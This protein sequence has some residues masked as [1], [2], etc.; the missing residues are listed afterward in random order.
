MNR[1]Q[2]V[3]Y[4]NPSG[5]SKGTVDKHK[6]YADEKAALKKEFEG[7]GFNLDWD[8]PDILAK[9]KSFA[10]QI[11]QITTDDIF[12][13]TPDL[14]SLTLP[15]ETVQPGDTFVFDE[16]HGPAV[17][18]GSYG[19]AIRISRPQF[20]KYT[21]TTNLKEVGLKLQLAQIQTG[22]YSASQ[23]GEYVTKLI[24]AWRMRLLFTTTLAGMSVYQSG[25]AGYRASATPDTIAAADMTA[26]FGL[27][28]DEADVKMLIGRR[29]TIHELSVNTGYSNDTRRDFETQGQI[30]TYAGVPL[31]KVNSFTDLDY[32]QVYPFAKDMMWAFSELPAGRWVQAAAL[33]TSNEVVNRNETLNIFYRWDDGVGIWHTDRIALLQS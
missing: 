8:S 24:A 10:R 21:A 31:L 22:K 1:L 3:G 23:L 19:A 33:R 13:D 29:K 18:Y 14:I 7:V 25:G 12:A 20:T 11:I 17:Y 6:L 27:I 5:V 15:T 26:T 32:G 9:L 4:L 16:L 30:G 28:S 2:S